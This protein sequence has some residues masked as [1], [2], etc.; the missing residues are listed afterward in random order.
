MGWRRPPGAGVL[1][2]DLATAP[3]EAD[4]TIRLQLFEAVTM[5]LSERVKTGHSW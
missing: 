5:L 4:D 1:L 2:P 3:H